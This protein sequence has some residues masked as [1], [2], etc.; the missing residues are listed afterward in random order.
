MRNTKSSIRF[1]GILS[2]VAGLLVSGAASAQLGG[3]GGLLGGGGGGSAP[4]GVTGQAAAAQV[5]VL[6]L[7]GGTTASL[8]NTGTLGGT[9]DARDASQNSGSLLGVLSAEAPQ[10]ST[11]GYPDQVDSAASLANLVLSV[12][13]TSIGADM[14][15]SQATAV[16]NGASSGSSGLTNLSVN[17]APVFVSGDPNQTIGIPGGTM[18]INEQTATPG[19][20]VVNAL[21]I[22]VLGVADAVIGTA[23]AAIQ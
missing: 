23:T 3:L 14:V 2:T 19:G 18:I 9:T 4:S 7:L 16:L 15:T 22:T 8:A 13:G 17:G 12:A 10:A 20:I 11:I 6:G 5:T 1:I 21:H